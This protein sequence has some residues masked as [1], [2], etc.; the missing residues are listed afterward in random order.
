MMCSFR[1]EPLPSSNAVAPFTHRVTVR[2]GVGTPH[3]HILSYLSNSFLLPWYIWGIVQCTRKDVGFEARINCVWILALRGTHW[4]T[5]RS[6]LTSRSCYTHP[7]RRVW[8][9]ELL[10]VKHGTKSMG[11][12]RAQ[13]V[14]A[15]VIYRGRHNTT[16][17]SFHYFKC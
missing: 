8:E 14:I 5:L 10:P 9:P 3:D 4:I 15:V 11:Y 7:T 2:S 13:E 17:S 6:D 12:R 1:W 16:Y